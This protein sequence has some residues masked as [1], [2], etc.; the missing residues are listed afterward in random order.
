MT[1]C[2]LGV[3][4]HKERFLTVIGNGCNSS[5]AIIKTGWRKDRL[6]PVVAALLVTGEIFGVCY[7]TSTEHFVFFPNRT[8]AEEFLKT[9]RGKDA[10]LIDGRNCEDFLTIWKNNRN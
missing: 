8:L 9:Y 5:T 4:N 3:E 1:K 2:V 10:F 6:V 7:K